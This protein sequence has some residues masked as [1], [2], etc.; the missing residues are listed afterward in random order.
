M[1]E[2]CARAQCGLNHR[3]QAYDFTAPTHVLCRE[4][5]LDAA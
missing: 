1:D 3:F 2:A 5:T 4:A